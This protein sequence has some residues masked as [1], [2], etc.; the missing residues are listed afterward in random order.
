V[1]K[2]VNGNLA[3]IRS[4]VTRRTT[5]MIAPPYTALVRLH[6]EYY[7][8]FWSPHCK[9]DIE[10]LECIQEGATKIVKDLEN[11][12]HEGSL[13]EGTGIVLSGEEKAAGDL[14]AL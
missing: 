13:A 11:K 5:E 10:A 4:S 6:L 1:D 9:K 12:S 7:A 3:S 14:I 2:K 8:Q